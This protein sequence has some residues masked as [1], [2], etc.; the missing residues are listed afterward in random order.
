[1][2]LFMTPPVSTASPIRILVVD[3][4][5]IVRQG[6]DRLVAAEPDLLITQAIREV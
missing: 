2:C 4:H 5:P 3:D 1:M 6:L